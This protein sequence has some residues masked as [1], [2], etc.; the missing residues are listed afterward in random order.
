MNSLLVSLGL[1]KNEDGKY[2]K[3]EDLRGPLSALTQSIQHLSPQQKHV[4]RAFMN[5]FEIDYKTFS[6]FIQSLQLS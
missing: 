1:L 6:Y 3:V 5:R 2:E 4:L